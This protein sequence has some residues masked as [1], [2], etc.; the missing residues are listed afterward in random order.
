MRALGG[1]TPWL[2]LYGTLPDLSHLKCFG[3]KVWVHDPTSSKLDLHT[4]E[5]Q[6]I[7]LNVK[8]HG[9]WVYWPLNKSVSVKHSVYFAAV[10]QLEGEKMDVPTSKTFLSEPLTASS[11]VSPPAPIDHPDA[12]PPSPTSSLLL[13]SSSS[14]SQ[15]VSEVLQLD[16]PDPEPEPEIRHSSRNRTASRWVR[17]LQEGVGVSSSCRSDSIMPQGVTVPGGFEMGGNEADLID[18]VAGAWSV[19]AGLPILCK[20]W[21]RLEVALVVDTADS[22][23]LEPRNLAEAKWCPN[24]PLWEQAIREELN[25]LRTA[26]TWR[27]KQAP[28]GVNVIGFKWVFKAKKDTSGKVVCYKARLVAQG[29]SQ[30]EGV[31]YFDTCAP[32]ARL[33]S[34]RAI[35]AMA[36]RL[37]LKLHQVNIKG[38][39]LN[40]ELTAD[41]VLYMRHPSGYREDNSGHVLRLLKSLYGLKQAGQHWY[42]KF[43]QILSSLGF[44]QCKVDQ[45]V[46]FK[47]TKSPCT[48]IVITVHVDDC[49]IAT[50]SVTFGLHT[51]RSYIGLPL[52][53]LFLPIPEALYDTISWLV[54]V[55][56]RSGDSLSTIGSRGLCLYDIN[57]RATTTVILSIGGVTIPIG[58]VSSTTD[59]IR[60]YKVLFKPVP[61]PTSDLKSEFLCQSSLWNAEPSDP[62]NTSYAWEISHAL[63]TTYHPYC[64]SPSALTEYL[65]QKLHAQRAKRLGRSHSAQA[66]QDIPLEHNKQ[67]HCHQSPQG[68]PLQ[69]HWSYWPWWAP[70]DAQH[71]GATQS[72]RWNCPLVAVIIYRLNLALLWFQWCQAHLHTLQHAGQ[73][74]SGAGPSRCGW[75]HGH[76]WHALS[77]GCWCAQLGSTCDTPWHC[78]CC[79]NGGSFLSQPWDGALA[80]G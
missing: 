37:N 54:S 61:I 2:A 9:H 77:G 12:S 21:L 52:F 67:H 68:R 1:M 32:V 79:G 47:H 46:F 80:C 22:E 7:G 18:E 17:D 69:A 56:Y 10:E 49:T 66:K 57:L 4:C 36:N 40:G 59:S 3:K 23:A 31:D 64:H 27:L 20:N 58:L 25:T 60:R 13:L 33:P 44:A 5:G 63:V 8:S 29:F 78:L 16:E 51:S 42:Q 14:S 39:Y 28:P 50:S 72:S 41:E 6:W 48:V 34:L 71:W 26:S 70:L 35:I 74:H 62:L 76:A 73:A 24:W 53:F 55:R 75:V 15:A 30:V 43:T 45:A 65:K 11:P 19:E 38:P